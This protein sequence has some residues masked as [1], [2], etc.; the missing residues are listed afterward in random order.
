MF[1]IWRAAAVDPLFCNL[2][3]ILINNSNVKQLT[4]LVIGSMNLKPVHVQTCINWA[5]RHTPLCVQ[6]ESTAAL[7]W[8]PIPRI[9]ACL[10]PVLHRLVIIFGIKPES[11]MGKL[12]HI[13]NQWGKKQVTYKSSGQQK[14]R[15]QF[16][17]QRA[18]THHRCPTNHAQQL[19]TRANKKVDPGREG[20]CAACCIA[21]QQWWPSQAI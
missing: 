5:P 4:L 8:F 20:T 10:L 12:L 17:A 6:M 2:A 3:T 15:A 11:N 7:F 16:K 18:G 13:L 9:I 14:T 19:A 1:S 21:S